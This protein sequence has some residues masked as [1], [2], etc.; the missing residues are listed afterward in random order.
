MLFDKKVQYIKALHNHRPGYNRGKVSSSVLVGVGTSLC[1]VEDKTLL[2]VS[3][4]CCLAILVNSY[5]S[6]NDNAKQNV[7]A[8]ISENKTGGILHAFLY[9][10]LFTMCIFST[11]CTFQ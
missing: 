8:L 3:L 7:S 10:T 1:G 2:I 11:S 6:I 5:F 9:I 4:A